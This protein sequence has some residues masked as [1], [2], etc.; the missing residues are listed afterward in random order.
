[1][2]LRRRER[3]NEQLVIC[4]GSQYG[5][6]RGGERTHETVNRKLSVKLQESRQSKLHAHIK[7]TRT[8][9]PKI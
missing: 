4:K 2:S 1:M 3:E 8:L 7:N 5:C 6:G 9:M